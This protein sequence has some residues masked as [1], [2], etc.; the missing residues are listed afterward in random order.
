[1]RGQGPEGSL[2]GAMRRLAI[3]QREARRPAGQKMWAESPDPWN[4]PIDREIVID[5]RIRACARP[6]YGIT[7]TSTALVSE[8][9]LR[10]LLKVMPWKPRAIP[11][12][13][14]GVGRPMLKSPDAVVRQRL[15]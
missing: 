10:E 1:M 4:S 8:M 6:G 13:A 3:S 15:L 12:R 5:R 7:V 9:A 2:G 11:A 14:A